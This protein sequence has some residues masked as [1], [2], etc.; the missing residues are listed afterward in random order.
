MFQVKRAHDIVST[1]TSQG[2]I[3]HNANCR[4]IGR[5]QPVVAK[6]AVANE[7]EA[8]GR[9]RVTLLFALVTSL[10]NG[11]EKFAR[12]IAKFVQG[13]M[14]DDKIL[15]ASHLHQPFQVGGRN[16]LLRMKGSRIERP[17]RLGGEP[18]VHLGHVPMGLPC[19]FVY[20][21]KLKMTSNLS[22]GEGRNFVL[23]GSVVLH[24]KSKVGGH[25]G[26]ERMARIHRCFFAPFQGDKT[27]QAAIGNAFNNFFLIE[28][29]S[30]GG[31]PII[32]TI[33]ISLDASLQRSAGHLI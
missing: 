33:E 11:F 31:Q 3:R 4:I 21:N 15:K 27:R 14:G 18:L 16:G 6:A 1:L 8:F 10:Q 7:L 22:L 26:D 12:P 13:Q 28:I 24:A 32:F 17:L 9:H 23:L 29:G 2:F 25:L 20:S 19:G 5:F 30:L